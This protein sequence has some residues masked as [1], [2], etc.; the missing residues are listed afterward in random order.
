MRRGR[1]GGGVIGGRHFLELVRTLRTDRR[2]IVLGC[3]KEVRGL[4]RGL[5]PHRFR[6]VDIRWRH[7]F[8]WGEAGLFERHIS[9]LLDE[10]MA[11]AALS[12]VSDAATAEMKVRFEKP[13][14][15]EGNITVK[16]EVTERKRRL[17][18]TSAVLVQGGERKASAEGLFVIVKKAE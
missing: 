4:D 5:E 12:L 9:T 8:L 16:A 11:H 1:A 10:A 15:T 6:L 7:V 17:L 18:Q 14:R 3:R 13:V 2:S